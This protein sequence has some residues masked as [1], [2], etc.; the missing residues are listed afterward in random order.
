M[1]GALSGLGNHVASSPEVTQLAEAF[2]FVRA[3]PKRHE[4][5]DRDTIR[6]KSSRSKKKPKKAWR[7]KSE[8]SSDDDTVIDLEEGPD[9]TFREK[10]K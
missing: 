8:D 9:G 4:V 7:E 3:V 6:D 10:K 1:I 5:E 2:G